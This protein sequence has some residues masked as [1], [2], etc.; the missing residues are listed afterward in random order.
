MANTPKTKVHQFKYVKIADFRTTQIH[1]V[2][3]GFNLRGQLNLN[4]YVETLEL[5]KMSKSQILGNRLGP[6]KFELIDPISVRELQFGINLDLSLAKEIV[7]WMNRH[8]SDYES[9]IEKSKAINETND[10]TNL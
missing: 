4:F 7:N 9:R 6:E 5:Q 3:G 2:Y 8:I 10:N 1:G